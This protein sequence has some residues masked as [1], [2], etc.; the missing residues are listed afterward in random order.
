LEI[1]GEVEG[2]RIRFLIDTGFE[3]ECALSFKIFKSIN[4]LEFRGISFE[5][6]SGEVIQTKAKLV[7][8]KVLNREVKAICNSFEGMDE[9]LLGEEVLRRLNVVLNYKENK[10][11]D[12]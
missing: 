1:E 10:I 6:V 12:P 7:T 11:D 3:G 4:T 2:R 5:T 9:N 8:L